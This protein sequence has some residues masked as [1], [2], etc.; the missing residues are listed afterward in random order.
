MNALRGANILRTK[1]DCPQCKRK[2]FFVAKED[3]VCLVCGYK[4]WH[5]RKWTERAGYGVSWISTYNG[6]AFIRAF[7]SPITDGDISGFDR[8]SNFKHRYGK[9]SF[10][11]KWDQGRGRVLIGNFFEPSI[12][13]EEFFVAAYLNLFS[14][15]EVNYNAVLL[16][17]LL[18]NTTYHRISMVYCASDPKVSL[19]SGTPKGDSLPNVMSAIVKKLDPAKR[20]VVLESLVK[21]FAS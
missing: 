14:R 12:V 4:R 3:Y 8:V 21:E 11:L 7:S 18:A 13:F 15:I 19:P 2:L 20:Q 17:C 5:R 6:R 16:E 9:H 1:M 10:L